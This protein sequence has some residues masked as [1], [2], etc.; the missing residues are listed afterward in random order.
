M[1]IESVQYNEYL[2]IIGAIRDTSKE[3]LYDELGLDPLQLRRWFQK[4]CYFYK[5]Y[6]N[7]PPQYLFKL[8]PLRHSSYTTRNV[9]KL[10]PFK[11]N[12]CF[13]KNCQC[14]EICQANPQQCS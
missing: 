6:K 14:P 11:T 5:F 4:L 13:L 7:E 1:K 9:E 10:T 3:K 12:H 2:A 8:V